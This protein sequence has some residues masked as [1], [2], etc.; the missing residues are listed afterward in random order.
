MLLSDRLGLSLKAEVQSV[1]RE[2]LMGEGAGV[3]QHPVLIQSVVREVLM[4]DP[5]ARV[6]TVWREVLAQIDNEPLTIGRLIVSYDQRVIMRRPT[7]P[8]PST[9]R[10][11]AEIPALREIAVQA[12]N[13]YWPHS[14]QYSGSLAQQTLQRRL[15]MRAFDVRSTDRVNGY[16]QQVVMSRNKVYVQVSELRISHQAQQAIQRRSFTAA[17]QVRTAISATRLAQQFIASRAQ[18]VIVITTYAYAESLAQQTVQATGR[19]APHSPEDVRSLVHMTVQKHNV[20][21]LSIDDRVTSVAQQ[22][23]AKRVPTAPFSGEYAAGVRQQVVVHYSFT[24]PRSTEYATG[25][26]QLAVLH[27]DTYAPAYAMGRHTAGLVQQI[28]VHRD[29]PVPSPRS[30]LFASSLG[31]SYMLHRDAPHP[32]DVIDPSIGRHASALASMAVLHRAT[33]SPGTV[34]SQSR[35]VF[36]VFKQIAIGDSSFPP[37]PPKPDLD[38]ETDVYLVNEQVIA[39]DLGQWSAVTAVTTRQVFATTTL[40]DTAGWVDAHIPQ[41]EVEAGGVIEAL[42]VGDTAFPDSMAVQ[43]DAL[44]AAIGG[45]VTVG[46]QTFPDAMIPQSEVEARSVIEIAALGDAQFTDPRIPASEIH[47]SLVGAILTLGDASMFGNFGMSVISTTNVAAFV[48]VQ[49]PSL[50]GIPLRQGPRPIVSVSMS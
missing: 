43:S 13:G 35:Y 10:S 18:S 45:M 44:V 36:N 48:V 11:A 6:Q 46:D 20:A 12:R 15:T 39:Q 2:V 8:L 24:T 22:S 47:S 30:P 40:G 21:P 7:M 26:V 31:V 33:I 38:H 29:Q 41:S 50:V 14:F 28:A 17:P 49:D 27:R 5:P 32:L 37:P 25:Q 34:A 1:V 16:G 4:T 3:D 9:I 42:V 19:P 23:V